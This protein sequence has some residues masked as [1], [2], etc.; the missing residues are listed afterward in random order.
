MESQIQPDPQ[1]G[2]QNL[3][4]H[5]AK[6]RCFERIDDCAT[7]KNPRFAA[8]AQGLEQMLQLWAKHSGVDARRGMSL[9]DRLKDHPDLKATVIGLLELIEQKISQALSS[10]ADHGDAETTAAMMPTDDDDVDP[11]EFLIKQKWRSYNGNAWGTVGAAVDMLIE[12]TAMIRKST[13]RNSNL[14]THFHRPD[15]YFAG[16]AKILARNWF[17]D[18]RRSLTDQ[19]GDSVFVRRRQMLYKM[20][21]EEKISYT[22]TDPTAVSANSIPTL[23]TTREPTQGMK[24]LK[25]TT[26]RI[27]SLHP[28]PPIFANPSPS[29]TNLSQIDRNRLKQRNRKVWALSGITEGSVSIEETSFSYMYP[30]PPTLG[31]KQKYGLCPY[32]SVLLPAS[33]LTKVAWRKHLHEDLQPY[34]CL[35]E[36]CQDPLQFFSNSE[37][38]LQHMDKFHGKDWPQTL[39]MATWY[40]DRG[41]ERV[42]FKSESELQNH[43]ADHHESLSDAHV[44]ALVRRNWG[45]GCREANVCPLCES[46]PSNIVPLM[47]DKD[48]ASVLFRHLGDHLKALALF[49]LPSLNTGPAS[50]GQKSSSGA[51]LP[52]NY[53]TKAH[54]SGNNLAVAQFDKDPDGSLTFD[55]DP[56]IPADTI[57]SEAT[58]NKELRV[59]S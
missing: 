39:H 21:H 3:N 20:K 35:S 29:S 25:P 37:Q 9:D 59:Q 10:P 53:D 27:K 34:V 46:T 48:N 41:H 7:Q 33:K 19:L 40:C 22:G 5:D 42:E 16:Y 47:N 2:S 14:P 52:T 58:M 26:S 30:E 38:W 1:Q 45:V 51:Q 12:L 44:N 56:R 36:K 50:G 6:Q 17:K 4:I 43:L 11:E 23:L 28:T 32:C 8:H 49:S 15:D 54:S 13:V 18:A 31:E 57:G 24:P 55:D